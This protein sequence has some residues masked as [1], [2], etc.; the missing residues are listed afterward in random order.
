M[1]RKLHI[2]TF[3]AMSVFTPWC[4]NAIDIVDGVYQITSPADF[5][6]Y[7]N[8]VA[9][10]QNNI[11]GL[12]T[13]DL[14]MAG[15]EWSP[16]G[17]TNIAF[18][19]TLDGGGHRI[20][21]LVINSTADYQGLFGVVT[22]GAVI[23]NLVLDNTC[24]VSGAS[25]V[26]G[27]AGGTS[28]TGT[29]TFRNV[30]NE[31]AVTASGLNAAGIVGVSMGGTINFSITNCYNTGD[32]TGSKQSAA[33]CAYV[34]KKSVLKNIYNTGKIGG[35]DSAD[36][37]LY[38]NTC[39]SSCLYDIEGMQGDS[40]TP[41]M[42]ASGE[43]A[44]ILN[45]NLRGE[46][47]WYQSLDNELTPDG[48]PT[49]SPSHGTVYALGTLN[50]NGTAS[51]DVSGYSNTDKSVRTPH[52]FENGICSV[53]EDVEPG[54]VTMTD[55]VYE[56][57]TAA[58]LN[59]F[60]HY[61]NLGT[62]NAK[63]KLTDDIDYTEYTTVK[64]M[65]GKEEADYT[66]SFDGQGHKV[67]INFRDITENRAALFRY[68]IGASVKN[69]MIDGE[70]IT[71]AMM[72]GGVFAGS[73]GASVVENCVSSVDITG[74]REGDNTFGGIGSYAYDNGIVRNCAFLGSITN[75]LGTGNGGIMGYAN[76]K[77]KVLIENCY[78]NA[79]YDLGGNS[80]I[81]ARNKPTIKNV[82]YTDLGSLTEDAAA[83][84]ITPEQMGNGELGYN[85]NG[86]RSDS[87][88][89]YQN[90]DNGNEVDEYPVPFN[91]HGVIYAVG[92]LNCDGT[93]G[94]DTG[95]SNTAN[96][97]VLPHDYVEGVCS[98]CNA[99]KDDY[100]QPVDGWY[101][102]FTPAQLYWFANYVNS[103]RSKSNA[104]LLNDIDFSEYT[105]A[106]GIMI[107]YLEND[108]DFQG[109]FD[110]QGHTVNVEYNCPD[111]KVALFG[112]LTNGTIKNLRTTGNIVGGY[113]TGGLLI[114]TYGKTIIENCVSA[115]NISGSIDGDA[116]FGGIS[117]S[118]HDHTI[119]RNCGFVGSITAETG[120]GNGG[121][122]GY[123]NG[124]VE[125]VMENCF[126]AATFKVGGN[127]AM[128]ARNNPTMVN[129]YYIDPG[130]LAVDTKSTEIN[131]EQLASGELCYLLNGSVSGGSLWL[132]NI[133]TDNYPIP[134]GNSSNVYAIGNL[135]CDGTPLELAYSNSEGELTQAEHNYDADGICF[136]C[137]GRRIS[138]PEQLLALSQDINS[139][140]ANGDINVT[141]AQDLDMSA[142]SDYVGIGTDA[143]PFKGKFNGGGHR[144][145]NLVINTTVNYQ[146]LF[147][148]ISGGAEIRNVVMDSTC[149]VKTNNYAGG[150]VGGTFGA[151]LV[152]I[153]NC[154]NEAAVTATTRNAA[155]IIGVNK[156]KEALIRMSN[157]YNTG[158][159]VGG[160]ESAGIS[161]WLGLSA[162]LT[163]CY[164][165]GSVTGMQA[166][167]PFAR[168]SARP[169]FVN[170]YE[171]I[172]NQV[173]N[174]T[175]EQVENGA[176]CYMLNDSVSGGDTFFQTLGED[177]HP[178]LF[179]SRQKVYEVNGS[180]TNNVVGIRENAIDKSEDGK[181]QRI[182]SVD[183]VRRSNLQKGINIV[184]NGKGKAKKV[185]VK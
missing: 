2:L 51:G 96:S 160:K 178:V 87:I 16:I 77:S 107:G 71:D 66:G 42:L 93:P 97:K 37:K 62:V 61:V 123:A 109:I 118:A 130:E 14:D 79:V 43:F 110:G 58:Q 9:T 114:S 143:L 7:G 117:A 78:M 127:S 12:I 151:G 31:A 34:G 48:H 152:I 157:C 173:I 140:F 111:A 30:G 69:I 44:F 65:I 22:A 172:G 94:S 170:C 135:N 82:Y 154:G 137:Y 67:T 153:E 162:E 63:A 158:T 32:V 115:V 124:G 175:T 13:A 38:R 46:S 76:G 92:T 29:V 165:I 24:S 101:E 142:I 73:A 182:Y 90:I 59:W 23:K 183:G 166:D 126:V 181:I 28:G 113:R 19:G 177:L 52:E 155:G 148:A 106:N 159:I 100:M 26:A 5:A 122:L 1:K 125:I 45:C 81:V 6:E 139:G 20:S 147:G 102:I 119:F 141:L 17:S 36:K 129:C 163:N 91:T 146:G 99:V 18:A 168:Y 171:T 47:P 54:F 105:A 72:A 25:Y 56:I 75:P 84:M 11:K 150:I 134:F 156:G 53:C 120:T 108:K 33:I 41:E 164:N 3:F 179:G 86:M 161:G 57:G 144:I 35:Y 98:F 185:Y 39:T 136:T 49:L 74:T 4:A 21:N 27:I 60:A 89:W 40:I 145:S 70:I 80:T 149:S 64:S 10:G 169:Y 50:C 176:L 95:F 121:I 133:G 131:A 8:V 167:R 55:S 85:L 180:Y 15:V 88:F 128:F 174:V 132:Q 112:F 83:T 103:G 184:I 68:I 104:K 116:T 138:K